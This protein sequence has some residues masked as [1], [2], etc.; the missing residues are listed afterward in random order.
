MRPFPVLLVIVV[1]LLAA[2]P[3]FAASEPA[4]S[5]IKGA[6]YDIER[7]EQQV[8]GLTP[9]KQAGIKRISRLLK[10]TEERPDLMKNERVLKA[11]Q[12]VT[13]K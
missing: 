7:A 10:L 1:A 9:N 4:D 11:L 5:V 3:L 13:F 12:G 8:K 2:G 6:L